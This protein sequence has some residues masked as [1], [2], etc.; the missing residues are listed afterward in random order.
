L[1][2]HDSRIQPQGEKSS[3]YTR[4]V[5]LVTR[6]NG[7]PFK[8]SAPNVP[9]CWEEVEMGS[10]AVRASR[11][12]RLAIGSGEMMQARRPHHK[13]TLPMRYTLATALKNV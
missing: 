6:I 11:L 1:F 2:R 13:R 7:A 8:Q 3:T 9:Q 4:I 5:H 10:F 12:H